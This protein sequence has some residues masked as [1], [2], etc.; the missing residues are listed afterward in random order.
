MG[1]DV[2]ICILVDEFGHIGARIR[3]FCVKVEMFELI[4]YY[5]PFFVTSNN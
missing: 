2:C 3:A 4:L 5:S 1:Q